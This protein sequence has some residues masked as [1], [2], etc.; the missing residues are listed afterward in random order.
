ML[1]RFALAFALVGMAAC[2]ASEAS[3]QGSASTYRWTGG[4]GGINAGYGWSNSTVQASGDSATEGAGNALLHGI[5]ADM[6]LNFAPASYSQS[7]RAKGGLSGFQ[8]GYN[9]QLG[10]IWLVGLEADL[11]GTF[12]G[13]DDFKLGLVRPADA[14]SFRS[15][16]DLNWFGTVRARLG[17]LAT[18]QLLVFGT[19]GFAFGQAQ[20]S[21]AITNHS[22]LVGI[23]TPGTSYTQC[24]TGNVCFAGSDTKL[25][26]G[27][28]LGGGF[29]WAWLANT[30]IKVEYM[31]VDLGSQS[32]LLNLQSPANGTAFARAK[33]DN[34]F[35]IVRAGLNV[36]F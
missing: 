29:E 27:W 3:A 21:A 2:L 22:G 17:L 35:D 10:G 15:E 33:F 4:Y 1:R 19:G 31:H 25:S 16:Q 28:T 36:K 8:L 9:W 32:I 13:G 6:T 24:A 18:N 5:F 7:P 20:V 26:G 14:Y 23:V 12:I 11:Q 34:D 30:T